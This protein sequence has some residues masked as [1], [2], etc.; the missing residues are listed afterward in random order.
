MKLL[1]ALSIL[2]A[3]VLVFSTLPAA[4][5]NNDALIAKARSAAPAMIS[6]NATV[7]FRGEVLAKGTNGWVCLP[8]TLPDDN[9]P[10]C[11]DATWM[12]MMQAVA[13]N[14][15]FTAD[16]IGVS[17][18]LQGDGGVSNSDPHHP[19]PENAEDYIKEGPHLM[20]IVPKAVMA[21]MTDDPNPGE[22]YVMWGDTP[23]A[24]IMVP[25]G[26]RPK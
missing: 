14:A 13:N 19:D 18:M 5:Q 8:E 10:M 6:D 2:P 17:Y 21:N 7:M 1:P 25:V 20:L 15:P 22:P 12:K 16:T 11:N 3:V 4:A 9:S 26:D 24:H 23:Y